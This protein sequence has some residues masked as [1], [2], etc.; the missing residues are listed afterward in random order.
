MVAIPSVSTKKKPPQRQRSSSVVKASKNSTT[1]KSQKMPGKTEKTDRSPKNRR[2]QQQGTS[3]QRN[4]QR[5]PKTQQM[6][7]D[8]KTEG[9]SRIDATKRAEKQQSMEELVHSE[10][11]Q[12][13]ESD[14]VPEYFK[15]DNSKI[16]SCK[17]NEN[18]KL[19]ENFQTQVVT[20]E[21][22]F[23]EE[24]K[25]LRDRYVSQFERWFDILQEFNILCYGHGSK[26]MV[27][28]SF[29]EYCKER[30]HTM[31]VHGYHALFSIKELVGKIEGE[32]L[33]LPIETSC[34]RTATEQ[35]RRIEKHLSKC[36]IPNCIILVVHNIDGPKLL[37]SEVQEILS[38]IASIPHIKLI[39]SID[40]HN[41][42]LLWNHTV[43]QR[44]NWYWEQVTTE[45]SY[46]VEISDN[47]FLTSGEGDE[48]RVKAAI[49]L[50][51]TLT[52][53]AHQ[54]FLELAVLVNTP[55]EN[56]GSV[57]SKSPH[58]CGVGF[59]TLYEHCRKKFLVSSPNSLKAVLKELKDHELIS[60]TSSSISAETIKMQLKPK[61]LEAVVSTL[62]G[63]TS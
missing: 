56:D 1:A 63:E 2:K 10:D 27:L 47:S 42:C 57:G 43:Y 17:E 62:R 38:R 39:A 9:G 52:K 36:S 24:K 4:T 22:E 13:E 34:N 35:I 3:G 33:Q 14:G 18:V 51:R 23:A 32:I 31:I 30:S 29:A 46:L 48:S 5:N 6:D 45:D 54:I 19:P 60:I 26:R 61:Q 44:L 58:P 20:L 16:E 15:T 28:N 53:N 49:L 12:D 37:S 41:A 25:E 11:Y 55:Q 40:H 59:H 8:A 7:K 50:F 21:E